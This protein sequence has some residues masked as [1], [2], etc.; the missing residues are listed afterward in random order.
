[1]GM[2]N[3]GRRASGKAAATWEKFKVSVVSARVNVGYTAVRPLYR[4]CVW[5]LYMLFT[6]ETC[7]IIYKAAYRKLIAYL[8]T[9]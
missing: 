3:I 1:M 7:C 5:Q 9:W 2:V 6:Y 8:T 4:S